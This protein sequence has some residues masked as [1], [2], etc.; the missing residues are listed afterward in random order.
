MWRPIPPYQY[1]VGGESILVHF[2]KAGA[3]APRCGNGDAGRGIPLVQDCSRQSRRALA[4]SACCSRLKLK[5][6][7]KGLILVDP[8]DGRTSAAADRPDVR[9]VPRDS[10]AARRT[11]PSV[12]L[13]HLHVC[14]RRMA[15]RCPD[16]SQ[17]PKHDLARAHFLL[18]TPSEGGESA[19]SN[20]SVRARW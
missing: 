2:L 19:R 6:I 14:A 1:L 8:W 11:S 16:Q 13:L 3:R 17:P 18:L 9:S 4:V 12:P 15:E 20:G 5:P 10:I 7:T